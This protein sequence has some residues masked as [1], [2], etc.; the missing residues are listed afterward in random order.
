MHKKANDIDSGI[1]YCFLDL[2]HCQEI[3]SCFF[4]ERIYSK[5]S[6]TFLTISRVGNSAKD[7]LFNQV[8]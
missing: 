6:S 5:E 2:L 8:F 7:K 1:R 4:L 3:Q